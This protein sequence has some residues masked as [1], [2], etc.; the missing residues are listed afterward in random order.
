MFRNIQ[1]A[2]RAQKTDAW[3]AGA[4]KIRKLNSQPWV[5]FARE[6]LHAPRLTGAV[7]PSSCALAKAMADY[8][9]DGTGLV[10]D[11][12]AGTGAVV[13][14]LL[15]KGIPARRIVAVEQ[16]AQLVRYL[17]GRFPEIAVLRGDAAKLSR[18]LPKGSVDCVVSSLPLVSLPQ[19]KREA[20][21]RELK[22]VLQGRPLVQFSY[23]WG[24]AFLVH[25]GLMC[26]SSTLVLKNLPPARVMK[27]V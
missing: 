24:G 10:V 21:V 19:A 4:E 3:R 14:A 13:A 27:F 8:V 5:I 12:G 7:C 22:L 1:H 25:N 17:R 20:V 23:L 26:I 11:L 16:S 2:G 6:W 15:K 9:P 18:L